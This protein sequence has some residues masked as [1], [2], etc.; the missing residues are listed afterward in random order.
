M[1]EIP[2]YKTAYA[3]FFEMNNFNSKLLLYIIDPRTGNICSNRHAA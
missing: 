1:R 3:N 2:T